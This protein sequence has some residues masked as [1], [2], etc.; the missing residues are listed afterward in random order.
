[1]DARIRQ[2][3]AA[4][5]A[6]LALLV[7]GAAPA[8]AHGL[9]KRGV[10]APRV[11]VVQRA[12]GLHADG[13]FGPATKRAVKRFQRRHGLTADGIVGS[14]TWRLI[15]QVRRRQHASHT[16]GGPRVRSRGHAVARLQRA[17]GILADG[18]FGPATA[19]AVKGFQRAHGLTADG[20]V[21]PATWSAL[22]I[23]NMTTVLR[24]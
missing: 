10:H 3:A 22:G 21:G 24:R 13:L 18:V 11:A 2:I 23:A 1:M 17:L 4:L 7:A 5:A 19:R 15:K 8:G 6:C 12:L 9:L 16:G 14:A 20:V